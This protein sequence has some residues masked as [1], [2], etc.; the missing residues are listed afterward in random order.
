MV[1]KVSL[2][3]LMAQPTTSQLNKAFIDASY[4]LL[5]L[6]GVHANSSLDYATLIRKSSM[7]CE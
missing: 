4:K 3:I 6:V 2:P 1:N 5:S 7:S